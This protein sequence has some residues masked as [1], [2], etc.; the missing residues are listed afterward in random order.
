MSKG[1]CYICGR[2]ADIVVSG[3]AERY[4]CGLCGEYIISFATLS[5]RKEIGDSKFKACAYYYFLHNKKNNNKP[6]LILSQEKGKD[7]ED[8][9]YNY[10]SIEEILNLY[11]KSFTERIDMILLSWQ[12]SLVT[13][14]QHIITDDLYKYYYSMFYVK[15]SSIKTPA[16]TDGNIVKQIDYTLD[17]MAQEGLI[18]KLVDGT[19]RYIIDYKGWQRIDELQKKSAKHKKG[20]IAMWFPEDKS[21][22]PTRDA[23]KEVFVETGYQISIIDEKQHNNQIVPEILYEIETS[24]FIVADLTRNRNGVY[25]EAGYAL[26]QGKEVILTVDKN[27]IKKDND[28]APHFDVAQ[29]NQIRYENLEDLKVQLFNRITATVGN[30]KDPNAKLKIYTPNGAEIEVDKDE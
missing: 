4:T 5:N 7:N 16:N 2:E 25:Y 26:G 18:K 28:N 14:N 8:N 12:K 20:F 11:P 13:L 19:E 24:D 23:I 1:V 15:Y 10:V 3:V 29:I 30:L 21:M 9:E 22:I 17:V 27:E 6:Y